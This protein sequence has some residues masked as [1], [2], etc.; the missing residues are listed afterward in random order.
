M[1]EMILFVLLSSA[2]TGVTEGKLAGLRP[3]R[4]SSVDL[5]KLKLSDFQ[6]LEF[7]ADPVDLKR[8]YFV[9]VNDREPALF[10]RLLRLTRDNLNPAARSRQDVIIEKVQVADD[11]K[12]L[13]RSIV[14]MWYLGA[15]YKPADLR[16]AVT[17]PD[18]VPHMIIS[19]KAYSRGW[20][21][22]IAQAHPMGFSEMQFGYWAEPPK[23]DPKDFI[24]QG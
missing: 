7:G 11:T 21:W 17:S 16:K 12:F 8:D 15:W 23:L 9:W 18:F 1:D 6:S 24:R 5:Q 2:L 10:E 22:R 20:I 4:D 3:K 13:A 14:L 19:A